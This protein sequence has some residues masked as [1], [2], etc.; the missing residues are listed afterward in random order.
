MAA[1][2]GRPVLESEG[3]CPLFSLLAALAALMPG[4]LVGS[5]SIR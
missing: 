4:S 5:T 1:P 3:S 2:H